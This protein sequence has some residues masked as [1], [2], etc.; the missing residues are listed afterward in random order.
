M[1]SSTGCSKSRKIVKLKEHI[2]SVANYFNL[3]KEDI[4][5]YDETVIKNM[6][7]KVFKTIMKKKIWKAVFEY[8]QNIQNTKSKINNIDYKKLSPQENL[9]SNIFSN[10][11]AYLLSKIR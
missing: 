10:E 6:K 9:T 3:I 1:N 5:D 2:K 8:L 7:K 4:N 11:E